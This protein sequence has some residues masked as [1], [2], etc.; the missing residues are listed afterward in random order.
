MRKN[1]T[2][3]PRRTAK[4]KPNVKPDGVNFFS[5]DQASEHTGLSKVTIWDAVKN[6]RL[7]GT[8]F[9]GPAGVRTT[10]GA[11]ETWI[12]SGAHSEALPAA[13]HTDER[14]DDG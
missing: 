13:E 5:A 4:R 2:K 3:P 14:E 10:L 11:L 7:A 1:T 8:D 9:G 12:E 6:G